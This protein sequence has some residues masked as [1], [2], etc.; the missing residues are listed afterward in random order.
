MAP[1][2]ALIVF[3]ILLGLVPRGDRAKRNLIAATGGTAAIVLLQALRHS[4]VGV[5][6]ASY[7][8]AY[9]LAG[10]LDLASG[11]RLMNYDLGYLYFSRLFS[12]LGISA[13]VY[14]GIVAAVVM[15]PI[16]STIRRCSVTAWLSILMYVT[17]GLF[18]F[19]FSGLRQAIA[20][21]VCFFGLRF[22]QEKR[23]LRFALTV[24]LAAA[25]HRSALVFV[26]AYPLYHM[27][28]LDARWMTMLLAAFG[29]TY[30]AREPLYAWA[31]RTYGGLSGAPEPT[32]AFGMLIGMATVYVLAYAFGDRENAATRGY[33]NLLLGAMFLQVFAGQSN[34]VMRAGYYYFIA[35]VLLIPGVIS[36]Q[37]DK[38]ARILVTYVVCVA[39]TLY[40]HWKTGSGYLD[41]SPYRLFW[42]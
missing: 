25:F 4:S 39:A 6:L 21:G 9:E 30:L 3:V 12:A 37:S 15:V 31:Y 32:G 42:L 10:G 40:F 20:I 19:S 33:S 7:M 18:V 22:I 34:V 24:L 16:G 17:L 29:A 11:A 14:L 5:D 26:F 41:V 35:V 38:R 27:P 23:L 8:P 13:Q 1:Y 28:R 36:A 2:Y